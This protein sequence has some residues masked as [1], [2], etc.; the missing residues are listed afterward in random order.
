MIMKKAPG[1]K[2]VHRGVNKKKKSKYQQQK[3]TGKEGWNNTQGTGGGN[4][5]NRETR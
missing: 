2:R 5:P 1:K 3:K 4:A